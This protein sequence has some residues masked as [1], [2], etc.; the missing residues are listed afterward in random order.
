M[1]F[2]HYERD[3][4]GF[5]K[6][7]LDGLFDLVEVVVYIALA[8]CA[9]WWLAS[10]TGCK[11]DESAPPAPPYPRRDVEQPLHPNSGFLIDGTV[12]KK[13]ILNGE[14]LVKVENFD[15]KVIII[16]SKQFYDKYKEGQRIRLNA[17]Y[18][19]K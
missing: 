10:C 5:N 14:Y 12:V 19:D 9:F 11:K 13:Y 4:M 8:F 2:R 6:R 16:H 17:A 1:Q 18:S 7:F 3:I 15:E